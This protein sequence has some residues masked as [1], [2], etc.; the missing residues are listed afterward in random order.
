M[1]C[2]LLLRLFQSSGLLGLH[3]AVVLPS[4]VVHRVP[5]LHNTVYLDAF[6]ASRDQLLGRFKFAFY[7]P[8]RLLGAFHVEVP[9]PVRQAECS[10]SA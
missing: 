8:R 9:R 7:S 10:H 3:P 2:I 1:A 6:L 5:R 4:A